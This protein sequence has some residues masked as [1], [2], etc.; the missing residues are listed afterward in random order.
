MTISLAMTPRTAEE[1]NDAVRKA[2]RVPAS[3]YGPKQEPMSVT[4]DAK[5]LKKVLADA[6]ESTIIELTG[7]AEPVEVLVKEVDFNPVKQ[8]VQHVDFYAIERGK[9]M[10]TNV[11]L[12]LTG[13]APAEKSGLGTVTQVL[14][15]VEVTC[16]PS[17]LPAHIDVDVATL[18]DADSKVTVADLPAMEGVTINTDAEEAIVVISVA[19]EEVDAD[20][21][22]VDMDAIA[23]EEKGKTEEAEAAE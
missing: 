18:T 17:S 23:V 15:E 14:R 7:D 11:A 19:K 12:E 16:R 1:K 21:E 10:T 4:V 6:G 13:E 8:G 20:P 3:V 5:E 2:G 9:D 22:A